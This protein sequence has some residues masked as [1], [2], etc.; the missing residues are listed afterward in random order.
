MS[1]MQ[2]KPYNDGHDET[3]WYSQ[4]KLDAADNTYCT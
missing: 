1:V 2:I 3:K 4:S